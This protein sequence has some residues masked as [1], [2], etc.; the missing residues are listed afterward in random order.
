MDRGWYDPAQPGGGEPKPYTY[1]VEEF[2]P[3]ARAPASIRLFSKGLRTPTLSTP[4]LA[5]TL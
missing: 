4:L 1:L 3:Q 5:N 2:L